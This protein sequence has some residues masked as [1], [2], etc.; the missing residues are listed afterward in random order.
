[1][2]KA[3]VDCH[4][5][6][7]QPCCPSPYLGF[8]EALGIDISSGRNNFKYIFN[9]IRRV[10]REKKMSGRLSTW[11]VSASIMFSN[12]AAEYAI[13]WINNEVSR[14]GI[15]NQVLLDC[16]NAYVTEV[17]GEASIVYMTSFSEKAV[18][19]ENFKLV[20]MSYLDF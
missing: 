3:V 2:L 16:M 20:L 11:P 10:A 18:V 4:A 13:K 5:I 6:Y 19:Y 1:L 8:P 12:A 7:P 14:D 17:T 15:E 9:E